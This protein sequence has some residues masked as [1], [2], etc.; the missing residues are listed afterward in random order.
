MKSNLI[1]FIALLACIFGLSLA[2]DTY[3]IEAKG[4]FGKELSELVKKHAQDQ[5]MSVNTYQKDE[6]ATNP[7][8]VLDLNTTQSVANSE[9]LD[10]LYTKGEEIY[11]KNCKVCHGEKGTKKA[12]NASKRLIDMEAVDIKNSIS[13]YSADSEYGGRLKTTMQLYAQKIG[14]RQ[15]RA[16]IYY[17][18]GEDIDKL[19]KSFF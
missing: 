14:G 17:L 11:N 10:E 6:N 13:F 4:E 2:E 3:V 19:E 12:L 16:I 15:L 18:K 7:N 9:N 8:P 1:K 5:N